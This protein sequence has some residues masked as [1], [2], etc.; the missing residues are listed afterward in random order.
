MQL[1]SYFKV[2][3]L[4]CLFVGLIAFVSR[5]EGRKVVAYRTASPSNWIQCS[6]ASEQNEIKTA[7]FTLALKQRNLD[8]L[9]ELF[10]KISDPTN[11]EF[12]GKHLSRDQVTELV[13]PPKETQEKIISW[14]KKVGESTPQLLQID[15]KGDAIIVTGTT[16]YIEALLKTNLYIFK[17]EQGKKVVKHLGEL[18]LPGKLQ[19]YI[20]TNNIESL[21]NYVQMITGITEFTPSLPDPIINKRTTDGPGNK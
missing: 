9:E 16:A 10:W 7:T 14:L 15:N 19:Q 2:A 8:K 21:S 1:S 6:K 11:T 17:N 18:T 4:I 13:S 3:A 20:Q 12:Y 5:P